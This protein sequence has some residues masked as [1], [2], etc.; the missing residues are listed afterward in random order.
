MADVE[1]PPCIA[2]RVGGEGGG[3]S[4]KRPGLGRNRCLE[5]PVIEKTRLA[6]IIRRHR[7][8][9]HQSAG[10]LERLRKPPGV[11]GDR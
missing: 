4:G 7:N 6:I 10:R 1:N 3:D 8:Q 5:H 2:P 11:T 9:P